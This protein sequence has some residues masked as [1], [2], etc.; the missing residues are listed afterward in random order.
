[1]DWPNTPPPSFFVPDTV[2]EKKPLAEKLRDARAVVSPHAVESPHK[3]Q[4]MPIEI[5]DEIR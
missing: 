3:E 5:L 1:M 2:R 4:T